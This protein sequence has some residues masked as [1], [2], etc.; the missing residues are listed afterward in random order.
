VLQSVVGVDFFVLCRVEPEVS[1][2]E[3]RL[4]RLT[5]PESPFLQAVARARFVDGTALGAGSIRRIGRALV[6]WKPWPRWLGF[7]KHLELREPLR[8]AAYAL[9]SALG[10]RRALYLPD[11]SSAFERISELEDA[12]G[13]DEALTTLFEDVAAGASRGLLTAMDAVPYER[14]AFLDDFRDLDGASPLRRLDEMLAARERLRA[15]TAV[16]VL[17][18]ATAGE[19]WSGAAVVVDESV[20]WHEPYEDLDLADPKR[21]LLLSPDGFET[22]NGRGALSLSPAVDVAVLP[23][24]FT[25]LGPPPALARAV[26]TRPAWTGGV[27]ISRGDSPWGH[28]I[29]DAEDPQRVHLHA[30]WP[31]SPER[32]AG[33]DR[34]IESAIRRMLEAD[35]G[36]VFHLE[37]TVQRGLGSVLLPRSDLVRLREANVRLTIAPLRDDDVVGW[38]PSASSA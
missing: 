27:W 24:P 28:W 25:R 19:P 22:Q 26:R 35:R 32:N 6:E 36:T 33:P 29:H 21:A 7:A 1:D 16:P 15:E 8:A 20:R 9:A 3:S 10:G 4:A 37:A 2:T 18:G 13:G 38:R 12:G 31:S 30:P 5:S 17:E 23:Y 34:F 11:C 14:A